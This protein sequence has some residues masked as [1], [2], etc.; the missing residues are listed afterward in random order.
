LRV[1]SLNCRQQPEVL[2]SL[3]NET[4]P[5][6]VGVMCVREL[7]KFIATS[8]S[9]RSPKWHLFLPS[10][11]GQCDRTSWPRSTIYLNVHIP[12]DSYAQL[13]IASWDLVGISFSL[14]SQTFTIYSVYNPP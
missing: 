3:L 12:S 13:R 2:K 11:A 4:S 1:L 6:D 10:T 7:P 14:H 5:D 9:F 8:P